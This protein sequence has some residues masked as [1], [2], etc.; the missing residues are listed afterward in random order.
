M[1]TSHVSREKAKTTILSHQCCTSIERGGTANTSFERELLHKNR[2]VCTD[3]ARVIDLEH[4]MDSKQWPVAPLTGNAE[5]LTGVLPQAGHRVE[6]KLTNTILRNAQ[7]KGSGWGAEEFVFYNK[8]K[9][10]GGRLA[11]HFGPHW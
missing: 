9:G 5:T 1:Y 2:D 10:P 8:E 11:E 4:P 3:W 7:G 6:V